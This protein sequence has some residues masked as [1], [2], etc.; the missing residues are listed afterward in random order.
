M[1]L[2]VDDRTALVAAN[3]LTV[4]FYTTIVRSCY[5]SER[6][7]FV[8]VEVERVVQLDELTVPLTYSAPTWCPR[9]L[10]LSDA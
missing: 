9:R 3:V 8:I 2:F 6:L 10:N 4:V 5:T 1:Y 7:S